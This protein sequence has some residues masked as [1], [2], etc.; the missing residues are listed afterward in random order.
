[1]HGLTRQADQSAKRTI[2][3]QDQKNRAANRKRRDDQGGYSRLVRRRENAE[4][5]KNDYQPGNQNREH[6]FRDRR[7][8][9]RSQQSANFAEIQG[10]ICRFSFE[11]ALL[12]VRWG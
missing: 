7:N 3:F 1:M 6:Q 12:I 4:A 11:T 10:G 9:L 5:E 2:Q 8:R